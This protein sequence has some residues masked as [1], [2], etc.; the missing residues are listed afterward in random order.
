M[1]R[2]RHYVVA[3]QSIRGIV[4]TVDAGVR[5]KG[6]VPPQS[7]EQGLLTHVYATLNLRCEQLFNRVLELIL[8]VRLRKEVCSF[9]NYSFHFVVDGTAGRVE[10][11][12]FWPKRDSLLRK[13]AAAMEQRS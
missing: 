12:Q 2:S 3:R 7:V 8:R 9:S 11:T 10:H 1:T 4:V 5:D 13:I 6:A